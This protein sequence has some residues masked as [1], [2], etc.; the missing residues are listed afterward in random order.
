MPDKMPYE[1]AIEEAAKAT[2][3]ALELIKAASPAISDAYGLVI[4]DT[5][6]HARAERLERMAAKAK[7]K[8]IDRGVTQPTQPPEQIAVPLLE[9][10]QA[11]SR[12]ELIDLWARLLANTMD[13]GRISDVR[14]AYIDILKKLEPLDAK[15]LDFI[16]K[17]NPAND[18]VTKHAAFERIGCRQ[19]AAI[20]SIEN[21]DALGCVRLF[22]GNHFLTLSEL[23][24]EIVIAVQA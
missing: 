6:K 23:G 17:L 22:G 13:P 5:I 12:D 14:A 18:Q 8:L 9:V 21:L 20:V 24:K 7:K 2:S 1:G 16:S 11:E 10:A 19:S 3:K 4:G 15:V